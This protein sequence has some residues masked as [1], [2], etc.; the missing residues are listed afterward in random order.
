MI[1]AM[2]PI[3]GPSPLW[4]GAAWDSAGSAGLW[5]GSARVVTRSVLFGRSAWQRLAAKLG[6]I[7][8]AVAGAMADGRPHPRVPFCPRLPDRRTR[9]D[10]AAEP[11]SPG[12][13]SRRTSLAARRH[14]DG[15][16]GELRP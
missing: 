11:A 3:R 5:S 12:A 2:T 6:E 16:R 13:A 14:P 10:A 7:V 4:A 1:E 15:G 9:H 8:S